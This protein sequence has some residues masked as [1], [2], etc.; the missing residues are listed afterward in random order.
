[1]RPLLLLNALAFFLPVAGQADEAA[2]PKD[3]A[4]DLTMAPKAGES[5]P[6]T[7]RCVQGCDWEEKTFTCP[8]APEE[9]HALI[10]SRSAYERKP[11]VSEP[12][13][14]L[15]SVCTGFRLQPEFPMVQKCESFAD[16]NDS[17]TR[18]RAEPAPGSRSY[19]G[20]VRPDTP[21]EQAGLEASD[22]L[23]SI[24]DIP[25]QWSSDLAKI[26]KGAKAGQPFVALIERDGVPMTLTGNFGIQLLVDG[27]PS[28]CAVA[29][30]ERL[31]AARAFEPV[32]FTILV[33]G[34]DGNYDFECLE[35]C[36]GSSGTAGGSSEDDQ[37]RFSIRQDAGGL[38]T[39]GP[40]GV[41]PES[42]PRN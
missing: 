38:E 13:P 21:V 5:V 7:I 10:A 32:Y 19:V 2:A 18:C 14:L 3:F 41:F 33:T 30:P 17:G 31:K 20:D 40:G 28:A 37:L 25:M 36:L 1:M 8:K 22:I 23:V 12:L 6:L 4:M 34:P 24:N 39:G 27:S 42:E 26:L 11:I 16:E 9:C 15:G 35:G 29:T